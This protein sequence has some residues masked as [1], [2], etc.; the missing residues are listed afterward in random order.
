MERKPKIVAAI[1]ARLGSRRLPDKV[2]LDLAGRSVIEHVARRLGRSS[3]LDNVVVATTA[4]A[5]DDRIAEV[6][7]KLGISCIRGSENDMV[8]RLL[9][10][11]EVCD[12]D[13]LVRI[14][15]DSPLIDPAWVDRAVNDF[16]ERFGKIS[17]LTTCPPP[18]FPEGFNF[19]IVSRETLRYLDKTL[20]DPVDREVFVIYLITRPEQFP[21]H[22]MRYGKNAAGIRLTLDYPEDF[23]LILKIF[24][25][26]SEQ[27]KD[28][29]SLEEILDFL[30]K[31]P[32]LIA[33]NRNRIDRTKY[34]Y[35]FDEVAVKKSR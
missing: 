32:Q 13:G 14:T 22:V 15:G 23:S 28:F 12:A 19:E 27:G 1:Q 18:S 26:F 31:N 10:A 9:K 21:R 11:A 35:K 20:T 4:E 2:L 30:E 33:I 5:K 7:E 24:R 17:F 34:P 25:H 16:R 29:F 8:Q 3:E 6:A